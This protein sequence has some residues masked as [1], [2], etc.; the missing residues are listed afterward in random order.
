[1]FILFYTSPELGGQ[2]SRDFLKDPAEIFWVGI[3]DFFRDLVQFQVRSCQQF[4]CF[5]DPVG[6]KIRTESGA[7]L[8]MER[9]PRYSGVISSFLEISSSMMPVW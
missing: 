2:L 1:M 8:P 5:R 6:L 4:L 9:V 7:G 3:T